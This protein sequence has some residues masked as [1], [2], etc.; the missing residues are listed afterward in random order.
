MN[1]EIERYTKQ[2]NNV[3]RWL[4]EDKAKCKDTMAMEKLLAHLEGE[5]ARLCLL[6]K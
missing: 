3:R 5:R 1:K 4:R 2:I 6:D